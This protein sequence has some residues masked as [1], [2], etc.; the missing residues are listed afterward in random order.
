MFDAILPTSFGSIL[1]LLINTLVAFIAIVVS[2]GVIAHN[3]D[4]KH[5]FIMAI[6]ALFVAPIIVAFLSLGVYLSLFIIPLIVWIILGEVLLSADKMTKLKVV[7]I[8]FV[9]YT[10]LNFVGLPSIVAGIIG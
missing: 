1:G 5:S 2:N 3:I 10:I 4:I 7:I 9:V 6:V 8:A